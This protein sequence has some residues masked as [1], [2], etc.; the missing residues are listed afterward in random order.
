[1]YSYNF[2]YS[3]NQIFI[4]GGITYGANVS[5]AFP[6]GTWADFSSVLVYDLDSNTAA[7]VATYGD[8][9]PVRLG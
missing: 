2:C 8:I 5:K 6:E 3:N 4:M 9:P 1:M 7:T